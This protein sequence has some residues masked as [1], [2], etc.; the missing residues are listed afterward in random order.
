MASTIKLPNFPLERGNNRYLLSNCYVSGI[1]DLEPANPEVVPIL[2]A[3]PAW[4]VGGGDAGE[5]NNHKVHMCCGQCCKI[6]VDLSSCVRFTSLSMT[7]SRFILR[8]VANGR[9][10][11]FF[12]FFLLLNNI[13]LI[14]E[15]SKSQTHRGREWNGG[16]Q[17]G[18]GRGKW[19]ILIKGHIVLFIEDE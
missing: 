4:V 3:L 14:S 11:F 15:I 6:R 7:S 2:R 16:Y 8:V 18:G 1:G 9:I 13:L 5:R 17:G 12:F 10:S 19:D